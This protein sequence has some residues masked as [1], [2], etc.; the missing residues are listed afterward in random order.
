[1]P[2]NNGWNEYSRLVLSEIKRLDISLQE[3]TKEVAGMR[4]DIAILKIKYGLIGGV[5]GAIPGVVAII[6][7]FI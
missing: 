2:D 5:I 3:L 4:T 1:M 7:K 6:L